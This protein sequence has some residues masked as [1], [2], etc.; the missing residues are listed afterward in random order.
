MTTDK[1]GKFWLLATFLLIFI[2]V[3]SSLLIGTRSDRGRPIELISSPGLSVEGS[4]TIE[5]AVNNPG[6]YQL[7]SG[8]TVDAVFQAAGGPDSSADTSRISLFVPCL[9][10]KGNAQLVDLNRA[11][12]WLL[13]SLPDIG[14]V[15]AQAIVE[16]RMKHGRFEDIHEITSVPGIGESTFEKIKELIT[17]TP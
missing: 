9:G 3:L 2:I 16:Y 11:D 10:E 4:I 6:T 1:Y 14:N 12:I 7:R 5:G 13:C 8:D 15:R 17:I